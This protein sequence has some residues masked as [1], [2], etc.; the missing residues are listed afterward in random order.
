MPV[1]C[2][3]NCLSGSKKVKWNTVEQPITLHR[4]PKDPFFRKL[5]AQQALSGIDKKISF[6]SGLI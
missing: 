1:C 4:F 3:L 6:D 5:W 2:F